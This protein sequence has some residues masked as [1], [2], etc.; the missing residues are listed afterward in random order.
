M[1]VVLPPARWLTLFK[2][3]PVATVLAGILLL[4]L[5]GYY[6]WTRSLN[7]KA[8][9]IGTTTPATAVFVFYE[10]LGLTGLG[11]GRAELRESALA[12]LPRFL[13]PLGIFT[14]AAACIVWFALREVRSALDWRKWL[15]LG[16]LVAAPVLGLFA[17]GVLTRFRVLGRHVM[18]LLPIVLL[19]VCLGV[20]AAWRRGRFARC[21]AILF[22]SFSVLSCLSVRFAA[23]H[24]KDDYRS[25]A[26]LAQAALA[27]GQTV[28]WNADVRPPFY[29]KFPV[30]GFGSERGAYSLQNPLPDHLTNLPAP[31]LIL[32]NRP[33]TYDVYGTV[34]KYLQA[35]G[36]APAQ[37]FTAFTAWVPTNSAAAGQLK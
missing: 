15:L 37:R 26:H 11:P 33:D 28:W 36:Y 22:L 4:A 13:V 12:S 17:I 21:A 32:R 27:A 7:L 1:L 2:I 16:C 35:R 14:V 30:V 19:V 34:G 20:A 6:D 29:Y 25:A 9:Q 3:A 31:N 18:P 8:T 5:L 10:L 24:R 23:R